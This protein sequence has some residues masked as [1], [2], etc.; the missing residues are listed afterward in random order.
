M[1]RALI[2]IVFGALSIVQA[3]A[4][5]WPD[6]PVKIIVP[7]PAG[8]GADTVARLLAD[9]LGNSFGQRF[10]VENRAGAGGMLG[11]DAVAKS[12]SDGYTLLVSSPAEIVSVSRHSSCRRTRA[13]V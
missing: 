2:A 12:A 5:T 6:R 13:R 7:F 3:H 4:Q 8:G 1:T 11:A 9:R 10:I